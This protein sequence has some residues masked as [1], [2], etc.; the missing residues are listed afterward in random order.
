MPRRGVKPQDVEISEPAAPVDQG[1]EEILLGRIIE[2][3]DV[4][5]LASKLAPE[6][7]N[8]LLGR[9]SIDVLAD[10]AL[11]LI[12]SKVAEDPALI[13]AVLNQIWPR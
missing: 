11:D 2:Q 8:R 4:P 3:L 7:A 10:R 5:T 13:D 6:L 12:A 1:L 9:I